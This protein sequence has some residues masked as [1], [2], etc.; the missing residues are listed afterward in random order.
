MDMIPYMYLRVTI[1]SSLFLL[2]KLSSQHQT[3]GLFRIQPDKSNTRLDGFVYRTFEKMSPRLCFDKCI[4]RPKCYSFNYNR[5]ILRCELNVKPQADAT[6]DFY[7]E[8]GYIYVEIE[9]YRR[10]SNYDPCIEN[11]CQEGESC[12]SVSKGGNICIKDE[13]NFQPPL[14]NIAVGKSTQQSSEFGGYPSSYAV[15]GDTKTLSITSEQYLPHWWV[16][17]GDTFTITQIYIINRITCC[18][19]RLRNLDISVGNSLDSMAVCVHYN[20]PGSDGEHHVFNLEKEV[21]GRYVK[22]QIIGT[23]YLQLTEVRV[24][25]YPTEANFC[26]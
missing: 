6:L 7:T 3:P 1:L 11:L 12:Q 10:V 2:T 5:Y 14:T 20:G 16:D 22:L 17:L 25:G 8:N 18:G 26:K 13:C 4:R 23:E 9:P 21:V 24:F 15:D 19:N